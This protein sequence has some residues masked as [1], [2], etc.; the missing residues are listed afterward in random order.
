[1]KIAAFFKL[2]GNT[3]PTV[4]EALAAARKNADVDDMI[5]IGGSTFIVAEAIP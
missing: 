3:Y 4:A 2:Q 5:F 1:M